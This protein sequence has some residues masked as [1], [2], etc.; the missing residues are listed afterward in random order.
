MQ[1]DRGDIS[2][3]DHEGTEPTFLRCD[4]A[5]KLNL[6]GSCKVISSSDLP[7]Y[8]G[9]AVKLLYCFIRQTFYSCPCTLH[10]SNTSGTPFYASA[11]YRLV[12]DEFARV[13][14][15]S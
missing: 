6:R 5:S 11:C 8:F 10:A 2:S 14:A 3:S 13:V 9:L 15:E 7:T 1:S 4:F 12:F